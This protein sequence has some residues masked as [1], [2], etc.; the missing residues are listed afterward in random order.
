[1]NKGNKSS[2]NQVFTLIAIGSLFL[3]NPTVNIF[4]PIPDF[5]GYLIMVYALG[6]Y[7]YLND[8][9]KRA[10]RALI[11]LS[12]VNAVKLLASALLPYADDTLK[13]LL[14]FVFFIGEALLFIPA[15]SALSEGVDY[16]AVRY[17]EEKLPS[18]PLKFTV[19]AFIIRGAASVLPVVPASLSIDQNVQISG[20]AKWGEFT[21][22][23]YGMAVIVVLAVCIPW[24]I[25]FSKK[26]M[27]IAKNSDISN[28]L[29]ERFEKE[30][31]TDPALLLADRMKAVLTLLLSA[32]VFTV[33][34][35]VDNVNIFPNVISALLIAAALVLLA[36]FA[37]KTAVSGII[38]SAVFGIFAV[39]GLFLQLSFVRENYDP[40]AAYHSVGKSAEMYS[41]IELFSYIE[42][43]FFMLTLVFLALTVKKAVGTHIKNAPEKYRPTKKALRLKAIPPAVLFFLVA[44]LSAVIAPMRKFFPEI[45]LI[46]L[47]L[48]AVLTVF[49]ILAY[50]F[51]YDRFY[52][53]LKK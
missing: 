16:C 22:L 8:S 12:V 46:N 14:S 10:H 11:R 50:T 34:M 18:L 1:M 41:K 40:E 37:K 28:A 39:I 24:V 25:S 2:K 48:V 13:L 35:Y 42:A 29:N 51:I 4:D 19:T 49:V 52:E 44:A 23:Y 3:F 9:F 31:L 47:L 43:A 17:T 21:N 20:V 26:S 53:R 32:S 7:A 5:I 6:R 30:I 33:Q 38:T 45:W 36:K 15:M 27:K